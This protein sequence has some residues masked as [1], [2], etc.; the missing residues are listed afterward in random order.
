[1][2]RRAKVRARWEDNLAYVESAV[3]AIC[4]LYVDCRLSAAWTEGRGTV[5][6]RGIIRGGMLSSKM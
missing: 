4:A 1:M 6:G 3:K 5:G 2:A